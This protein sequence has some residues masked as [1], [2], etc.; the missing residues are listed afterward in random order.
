V[1]LSPSARGTLFAP[2]AHRERHCCTYRRHEAHLQASA[3]VGMAAVLFNLVLN[4]Q[5]A[6]PSGGQIEVTTGATRSSEPLPTV[7]GDLSPVSWAFF[8]VKDTG[9]GIDPAIRSRTFELFFTTRPLGVDTGLGLATVL[10]IAKLASCFGHP[11][12]AGRHP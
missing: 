2:E 12:G 8:R 9:G 5:D 10:R 7:D 11:A 6:M 1:Y 3:S 4:A